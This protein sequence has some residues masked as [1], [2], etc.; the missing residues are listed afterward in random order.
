MDPIVFMVPGHDTTV[1]PPLFAA[2]EHRRSLV[3]ER[4]RQVLVLP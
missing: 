3:G 4:E 1:P 2:K